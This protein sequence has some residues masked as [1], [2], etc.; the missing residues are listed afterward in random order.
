M[1]L[2]KLLFKEITLF[3][4]ILYLQCCD[5]I[6]DNEFLTPETTH[7]IIRDFS[8][9]NGCGM[10]IELDDGTIIVPYQFDTSP[11]LADGQEVE[12]TYTELSDIDYTC[13]AG[14]LAEITW[15][16]ILG[17]S[18]II[19]QI[20]NNTTLYTNLPDDPFNILH[21][22]IEEDCLKITLSY[23]GGCKVHEFI[24]TYTKLPQFGIYSGILTLSHNAHGD[25]CEALITD[26]IC[27]N[28]TSLQEA[29]STMVR[30]NL[31]KSGDQ[32][33]Q[34]IIDYYYK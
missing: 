1:N 23:G 8:S 10:V 9:I 13:K 15:L 22:E 11:M 34:L 2:C 30:L 4:L 26:T 29:G 20:M 18:H 21:A 33:Y 31:V 5:R 14:P 27:Y 6:K 16:K 12:I 7:G 24:M 17:C 3:S 25:L 32:Y 19:L 28:L